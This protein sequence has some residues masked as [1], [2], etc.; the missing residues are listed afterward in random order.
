VAEFGETVPEF[1]EEYDRSP[2][3][4][5]EAAVLT[6]CWA[7]LEIPPTNDVDEIRRARRSL[8]RKWHPDTV[9]DPAQKENY[10]IR[11]AEINAAHDEA[12]HIAETTGRVYGGDSGTSPGSA[13]P[14]DAGA[15]RPV[16]RGPRFRSGSLH[17]ISPVAAFFSVFYLLAFR[18]TFPLTV[19]AVIF[20]AGLVVAAL[21][22]VLLY[23][24]LVRPV[25][26]FL[27]VE[28][29]AVLPWAMLALGNFGLNYLL[30][31]GELLF[32]AGV[33]LAIPLWCLRRWAKAQRLRRSEAA[34]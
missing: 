4:S 10:T 7:I 11:C 8:M 21:V 17:L 14:F 29:S 24:Y 26:S 27:A 28:K 5:W 3:I 19:F 34:T 23:Y 20:G 16:S 6:R 1:C 2:C 33:L 12:V 18:F 9:K 15:W 31:P 25:L 32:Q 22:D 30:Q 13:P